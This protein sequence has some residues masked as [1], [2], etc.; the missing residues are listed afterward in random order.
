MP[1]QAEALAFWALVC[2]AFARG[3]AARRRAQRA[4]W[5]GRGPARGTRRRGNY[6]GR[7]CVL[8]E[9]EEDEAAAV[10]RSRCCRRAAPARCE[11]LPI[12]GKCSH[13]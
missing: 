1:C 8:S 13:F 11:N 4:R 3:G 5:V 7:Q 12:Y 9:P 6:C 2:F 10:D